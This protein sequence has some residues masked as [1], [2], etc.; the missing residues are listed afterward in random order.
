M[1]AE[2]ID[3][4]Y[5]KHHAGYIKKLNELIAGTEF[6]NLSLAEILIQSSGPVFNN[7]AQ[8]W[9]HAFFWQCLTPADKYRE[10]R[11]ALADAIKQSF[12]SFEH[13][14]ENF[15]KAA[16]ELFGSGWAWLVASDVDGALSIQT[17]KDAEN[18]MTKGHLPLLTLDVWEHAYY[19]DYRN[20]RPRFA[21]AVW[22]LLNWEF[23][24]QS[25]EKKGQ[26][27]A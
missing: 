1:S 26:I 24:E 27:A 19:I 17:T 4:H 23:A 8:A 5:N 11:G 25:F 2:T 18:P 14:H 7:S 3:Y 16:S 21:K 10:P 12:G 15:T 6:E 22:S 20:E 9:N 13:F